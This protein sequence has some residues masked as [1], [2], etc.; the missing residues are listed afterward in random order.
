MGDDKSLGINLMLSTNDVRIAYLI[1]NLLRKRF[2]GQPLMAEGFADSSGVGIKIVINWGE[3]LF[4]E[5]YQVVVLEATR[6]KT[7]V[8][9]TI[10]VGNDMPVEVLKQIARFYLRLEDNILPEK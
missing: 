8:I 9:K 3:M 6:L 2:V 7:T 5:V 1:A 10:A 4:P